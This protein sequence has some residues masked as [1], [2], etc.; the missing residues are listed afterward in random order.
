MINYEIF[1]ER[2]KIVFGEDAIEHLHKKSVVIFGL[3][4]VGAAAAMDLIRVG[5]GKLII[6]DFDKVEPSN[7]NRLIIGFG[8]TVGKNKVDVIKEFGI[9]INPN[10]TVEDHSKFLNGENIADFIP[11]N[12]DFYI[13]ASGSV[14]ETKKE[15]DNL[16]KKLK[17]K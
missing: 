5:V 3:G 10:L 17:I 13:D 6:V 9:K 1:R 7:L 11:E 12:A 4:G 15:V 14:N 2:N 16:L 8:D